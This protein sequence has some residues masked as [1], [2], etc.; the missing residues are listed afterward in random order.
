MCDHLSLD[1]VKYHDPLR[2]SECQRDG[3]TGDVEH[4]TSGVGEQPSD[5]HGSA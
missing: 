1:N 4:F 5:R 3:S 2:V